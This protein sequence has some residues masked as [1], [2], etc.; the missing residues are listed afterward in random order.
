MKANH[1]LLKIAQSQS[2]L[3]TGRQAVSAGI[4]SRNHSY[5]LKAGNWSRVGRGIYRLNVVQETDRKKF[6]FFQL[7]SRSHTSK[8]VGVFSYETALYLMGLEEVDFPVKFHITVPSGFRRSASV[9]EK[10]ILHY[11]DLKDSERTIKDYLHITDIRRTFQD[12]I[13]SGSYS[14]E[15]IKIQLRNAIDKKLISF[16]EIEKIP[17]QEEIKRIFSAILF[18]LS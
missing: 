7:W 2:G 14:P 8:Q 15:W 17:V 11:E 4:D 3:F 5:H 13:S 18:E 1:P 16:E 6:F 12:I 10:L 9:P